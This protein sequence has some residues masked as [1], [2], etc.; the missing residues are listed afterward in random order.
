MLMVSLL[1]MNPSASYAA[2]GAPVAPHPMVASLG[3]AS[4]TPP[5]GD[6]VINMGDYDIIIPHSNIREPGDAG[7]LFHT[8]IRI[9]R[10]H[11]SF[12]AQG[13]AL[14]PA[15]SPP[16]TGYSWAN[17]PASLACIAGLAG[18]A[19]TGCNPYTTFSNNTGVVGTANNGGSGL[20][21]IVDAYDAPTAA[22]DLAVF[23]NQFGLPAP[24][25]QIV[26]ATGTRPPVDT[27]YNGAWE[28]EE[29]LD[30]QWVHAMAPNAQIV[31][32]EAN[33]SYVSDM[34]TAIQVANNIITAAGG[35][36]ISMSY[37]TQEWEGETGYDNYFTAPNTTYIASAGDWVFAGWPSVS[38]NVISAGGTTIQRNSN[39]NYTG[40]IPWSVTGE[41]PSLY[42]PRPSYQNGIAAIVGSHR[43]IPD[44]AF[45]GDPN[46]GAWYYITY[47]NVYGTGWGVIGG[48]SLSAPALA[49]LLNSNG[50][51]RP[52]S[53]ALAQLYANTS[54]TEL[55]DI[56]SGTCGGAAS[57]YPGT[58]TY[59]ATTGWD[60]CSGLGTPRGVVP[61]ACNNCM[62]QEVN[63]ANATCVGAHIWTFTT[64]APNFYNNVQSPACFSQAT[65]NSL[66]LKLCETAF[67][68]TNCVNRANYASGSKYC[69]TY[70]ANQQNVVGPFTSLYVDCGHW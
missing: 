36:V 59:Q 4:V 47:S 42:E 6:V 10:P 35:G 56:V 61:T 9:M 46:S 30:T 11:V 50:N 57:G 1:F 69:G 66:A 7:K 31:L 38:P 16:Y 2:K 64:S 39:G 51:P 13:L 8:N 12:A 29:A 65:L 58:P 45:E 62:G 67:P 24:N 52:T 27:Y 54:N 26:Y 18:N 17:T 70:T 19:A 43:G 68:D 37:A 60:F 63:Y 53:V 49:G 20:I 40:Q 22:N 21:V 41:G 33:S 14:Q 25:F 3:P 28:A 48:T 44:I 32:V 5:T 55:S 34:L 23:S 15:N